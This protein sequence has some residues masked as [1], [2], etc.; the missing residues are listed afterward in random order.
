MSK[1]MP[2]AD[3][4]RRFIRPGM[5]LHLGYSCARPNAATLEVVRQFAGREPGF[6][7][8]CGGLVSSQ[9]PLV[10]EGVARK[11]IAS[12]IGD[13]YPTGGPNP[14]FQEAI[15]SGELE[16]ENWSLWT[17]IARLA[18][19]ALNVPFFP[20]N[21]IGDS[22]LAEAG[23][24]AE[25]DDPFGSGTTGVVSAL[26]PD[27]VLMHA[28]AADP[29]GNLIISPPYGESYWGALA[30]REGVIATVER[31]ISSEELHDHQALVRIPAHAVVAVCPAA[32]GSH[33]Y[34]LYS[35]APEFPSYVE[36]EAFILEQRRLSRDREA[37]RQWTREWV[38]DVPDHDGYLRKLGAERAHRL[39]G[40]AA[41][42]AWRLEEPPAPLPP[43]V[44]SDEEALVVEAARR[45]VAR[46]EAGNRALLMTGIGYANLAAWLAHRRLREAGRP[47]E[48][49][50]E[51]GLYGY[52]PRPGDPF[53]FSNRNL[54]TASVL[55][56]VM[57]ILGTLVGGDRGRCLA[58]VGA[59][60][61]DRTGAI[62]STRGDSGGFL[63]GSGG[64]ND[65]ASAAA[66]LLVAMKLGRGRLRRELPYVTS[67]GGRVR[68]VVA[69]PAVLEKPPG[70]DEL[71]LTG[72]LPAE[73]EAVDACVRR[74]KELCGW[75][76]RVASSVERVAPPSA[77]DLEAIRA[78][79]PARVYLGRSPEAAGEVANQTFG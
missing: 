13:N 26:R 74:I 5:T 7:V 37:M 77:A 27:V 6:T 43:G 19:G 35:P 44:W 39:I 61:I 78:F 11:V 69:F 52:E 14:I 15:D 70:E 40:A 42:D 68:T 30:A 9:A 34:G 16:V 20:V 28:A 29:E 32:L 51:I 22:S 21:S 54:P 23:G 24:F 33:P 1:V 59:G 55:T 36:D 67:P 45:I 49:M 48:L 66:E 79:D 58:V 50:A 63:V 73:G 56:D 64:A 8:S 57:G 38:L 41:R 17:V 65:I 18:A 12:F 75:E 10:T 72:C 4:V 25:V 3:A 2:L 47:V 76:L 46:V 71:M 62:N 53:I 31:V 60:Q